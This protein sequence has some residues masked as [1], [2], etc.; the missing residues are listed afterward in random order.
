M[1]DF[2]IDEIGR[3]AKQLTYLL[4]ML[5]DHLGCWQK[6]P[7]CDTGG[8]LSNIMIMLLVKRPSRYGRTEQ[9]F[10]AALFLRRSAQVQ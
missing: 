4:S 5:T 1:L 6:T 7:T 9:I 3:Q 8:G 10:Q 2:L